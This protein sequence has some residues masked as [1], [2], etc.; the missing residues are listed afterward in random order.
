MHHGIMEA[1]ETRARDITMGIMKDKIHGR[2]TCR[3]Y[4]SWEPQWALKERKESSK[5]HHTSS[6]KGNICQLGIYNILKIILWNPHH[7]VH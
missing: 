5:A 2:Q 6:K 4:S 3:I 1:L 7:R